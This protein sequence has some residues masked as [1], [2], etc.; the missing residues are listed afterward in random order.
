MLQPD[1]F[2]SH[3][4][5]ALTVTDLTRYIR[6]V[7]E[8]D[9]V[10]MNVRV[11]GEI[12]NLSRPRSG[13]IYFTL[14]DAG[15]SIRCVIWRS[16][17]A[18]IPHDLQNGI[19]VEAHGSIGVYEAGGQYQL[20]VRSV[21]PAGEGQLYQEFLR[22]KAQLEAEGLFD[23]EQKRQIPAQPHKIGIVTSINAAALQDMLNT[24]QNR[25]PLVE[26]LL[27]PASVQGKVAPAEIVRSIHALN[28]REDID[29]ILVARGGGSLED[30]WCFN[31]ERV[32]RAIAA[33]TIPVITGVGHETDFTLSDFAADLRA[34]TP[35]A[36]AVLATPDVRDLQE[37]LQGNVYRLNYTFQAI[38][39]FEAD[40]LQVLYNRLERVSPIYQIQSDRQR[41]DEMEERTGRA[42]RHI[43]D[44]RHTRIQGLTERLQALNPEAVLKRGYAIVSLDDRTLVRSVQQVKVNEDIHIQLS[45]GEIDARTH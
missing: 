23:P 21:H 40:R 35:T 7:L 25:Y 27:A 9:P 2:A 33:S 13:H 20:Y 30:L 37:A 3:T 16:A 24:L 45:D 8:E 18:R 39:E 10:L 29:V 44:L 15:A 1:L 41:L 32:V 28:R 4:P 43:L 6:E 12:S 14:K 19:A 22:L 36:A 11:E 31:D 26:V 17:A 5:A 38:L 34:P 42:L